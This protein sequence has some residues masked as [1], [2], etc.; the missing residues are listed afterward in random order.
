ME[1]LCHT[2]FLKNARFLQSAEVGFFPRA[3]P[4]DGFQTIVAGPTLRRLERLMV[5]EVKDERLAQ[6][7][8]KKR[9]PVAQSKPVGPFFS[10]T[11]RFMQV[12]FS[13]ARVSMPVSDLETAMRY[14]SF[15]VGPIS[16]YASQYGPNKL[17]VAVAAIPF[18]APVTDG[19][20]NDTILSG[21]VDQIAKANGLGSDSCLVFLNP[22]GVV[23]T[24]ADPA[25]GV[26]G[27]HNMSP[28]GVPYAF[29][30]VLGTGLT[31]DDRKDLYAT[32]LSHEIAEMDVDPKADGSNPEVS[33]PCAGNCSVNYLNYFDSS[34]TWLGGVATSAYAFFTDGIATPATVAQCP[35][36]ASSCSYPPPKR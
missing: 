7:I 30:N 24:D 34:G 19:K 14:A 11:L 17:S 9:P 32:A 22:Q 4:L 35:A 10:G 2:R 1:K 6:A 5:E 15:A 29:V 23:N 20:Y 33:D 13:R 28:S 18:D 25:Q 3:E 16:A 31:I 27:Y 8:S 36:P 26:L 12:T 21:W